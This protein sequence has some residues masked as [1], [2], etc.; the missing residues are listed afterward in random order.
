MYRY[1]IFMCGFSLL[2]YAHS[3][4]FTTIEMEWNDQSDS[5]EIALLMDSVELEN[6]LSIVNGKKIDLDISKDLD[7]FIF[8]Y[9]N[10]MVKIEDKEGKRLSLEWVGKEILQREAWIYFEI[11]LHGHSELVMTNTL[12]FDLPKDA[13]KLHSQINMVHFRY[14]DNRKSLC[15]TQEKKTQTLSIDF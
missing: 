14:K 12:L 8:N 10:K 4:H 5:L 2:V 1:I 15:F 7:L 11:P 9:L 3:Y 13:E 6:V